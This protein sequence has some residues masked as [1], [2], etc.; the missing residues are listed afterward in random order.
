MDSEISNILKRQ[1]FKIC[2]IK[3]QVD[4]G[5]GSGGGSN[6]LT[7][8]GQNGA[9]YQNRVNH[10]GTQPAS[11]ITG[12][13]V[14]ATSGAYSSLS[15]L[16]VIPTNNNQLANGASY[17]TN[18]ALSPYLTISSASSNY[19]PL[20]GGIITGTNGNGYIGLIS[21]SV[22]PVTPSS[23]INLYSRSSGAFSWKGTNGFQ[24]SFLGTGITADRDYTLPDNSGTLALISDLSNYVGVSSVNTLTN[25]SISDSLNITSTGSTTF[26][27]T[28]DQTNNYERARMYWS[29]NT[30][31]IGT[32]K[33]GTGTLRN[34]A[35]MG[36]NVGIGTANP[37][38]QLV[39][40][41]ATATPSAFI[42]RFVTKTTATN[43]A[44]SIG[45]EESPTAVKARIY[46]DVSSDKINNNSGF[47]NRYGGANQWFFG[48][49]N[50]GTFG[51]ASG[52]TSGRFMGYFDCINGVWRYGING[53][54]ELYVGASNSVYGV[55]LAQQDGNHVF[56]GA[57]GINIAIPNSSATLDITSTTK[58]FLPPRMTKTQRNA[59]A[60]PATG[61]EIYQTDNIPGLRVYNGTN[62]MRYTETTD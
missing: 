4:S 49:S 22:N 24:R 59:I 1:N 48:M 40:E 32:E 10:T 45:F 5:S 19:F 60:S 42:P 21:Q 37:A 18:S 13:S 3:K 54:G 28:T 38:S 26:Y 9:Y 36:G 46:F 27:N 39:I 56:N 47:I 8:E 14:V 35:M 20:S 57:V 61:L 44:I 41:G 50:E 25:K 62:W 53:P 7:L 29:G 33:G 6:A 11:T 58:G 15:G 16:P 12:L 31:N 23:G 34:I 30:F 43:Q 2:C 55:K 51:G 17:I 52:T